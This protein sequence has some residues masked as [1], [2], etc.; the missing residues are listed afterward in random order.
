VGT[1]QA[2]KVFE[3]IEAKVVVPYG[4]GKEIFLNTV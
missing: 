3:N 1:K 4:E 2:V